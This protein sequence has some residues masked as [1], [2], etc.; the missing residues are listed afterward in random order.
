MGKKHSGP[1][2]IFLLF[3]FACQRIEMHIS[4]I[5]N[6]DYSSIKISLNSILFLHHPFQ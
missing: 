4:L 2:E 1:Q 6:S 5:N 3:I